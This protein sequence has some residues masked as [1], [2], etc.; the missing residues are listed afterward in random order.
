[1]EL[2]FL[3]GLLCAR[4]CF[5]YITAL[6][7]FII[8]ISRKEFT[9]GC[10]PRFGGFRCMLFPQQCTSSPEYPWNVYLR[11]SGCLASSREICT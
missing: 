6:S 2:M 11:A 1:M 8:K 3:E 5:R 4:C 9:Q 10:K 7:H